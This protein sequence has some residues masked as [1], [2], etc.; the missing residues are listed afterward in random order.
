MALSQ[1]DLSRRGSSQASSLSQWYSHR[2]PFASISPQILG[3]VRMWP[4]LFIHF[5]SQS[6]ASGFSHYGNR[7]IFFFFQDV[8]ING[9]ALALFHLLNW[10]LIWIPLKNVNWIFSIIQPMFFLN[11]MGF[12]PNVSNSSFLCVY[13]WWKYNIHI[14]KYKNLECTAWWILTKYTHLSSQYPD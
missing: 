2:W 13:C 8:F 6:S 11:L 7:A 9:N 3:K 4:S 14:E 12:F 5:M 10:V 1:K